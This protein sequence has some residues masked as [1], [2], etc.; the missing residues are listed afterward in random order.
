MLQRPLQDVAD[1]LHVPVTVGRKAAARLHAVLVDHAQGA[2][3]HVAG[4]VVLAERKRVRGVEPVEV[5]MTAVGRGA[6]RDHS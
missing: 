1:D 3:P 2:K 5:E 4:V 6:P